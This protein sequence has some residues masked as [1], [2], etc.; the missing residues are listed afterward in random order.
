[1]TR[2][3]TEKGAAGK[4]A[5]PWVAVPLQ[6]AAQHVTLPP[7]PAPGAPGPFA[8]ADADRVRGILS[9]AGFDAIAFADVRQPLVLA[10]GG[11]VEEAARLLV[12]GIGPTSAVLREAD[13]ATRARVKDAVLEALAPFAG[14]DGVRI[15]SA[16]WVVSARA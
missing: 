9:A 3:D 5:R 2:I 14:A 12:E 8:F 1:M 10:G 15:P 7:P 4:H 6:A 13:P 16:A 11:G